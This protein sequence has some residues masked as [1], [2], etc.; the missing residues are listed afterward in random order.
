VSFEI[1]KGQVKKPFNIILFGVPGIGKS[2]FAKMAPKPIFVGA[3]E[4]DEL[5]VDRFPHPK[6][7]DEFK[8]QLEFL[9]TLTLYKTVV[10]DTLD[11]V[12]RLLHRKILDLDPKA[13]GVL[14]KALGGYGKAFEY[15]ESEM[16]HI[17]DLLK[18]LRDKCG[19]N[20]ILLAHSKK[21]RATDT[22][23]GLEYDTF[24]LA[25]HQRVQGVFVDWV[26]A[27]FFANYV[28]KE[29]EGANTDKVFAMGHGKRVVYTEKRPGHLGKNRFHLPY[30]MGLDF[31]EFHRGYEAFYSKPVDPVA[32]AEEIKGLLQNVSDEALVTVVN[33]SVEKA[34]VGE[35]AGPMLVKILERVRERIGQ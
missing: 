26:S 12:E 18:D 5:D 7:F 34:L 30:E 8:S 11:S 17:R 25:L 32:I 28:A 22:V 13:G 29:K 27:V 16:I 2:T 4:N 1:I 21:V 19:M 20:V 15:A 23:L 31:N 6:S 24:E 14:G 33:G 9:K 3:E 10:I 35:N